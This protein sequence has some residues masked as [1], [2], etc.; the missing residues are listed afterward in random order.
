M[1]SV[2]RKSQCRRYLAQ[3]YYLRIKKAAIASQCAWRGRVARRELRKLQMVAKETGALQAA[4]TKLENQV[5]ELTWRLQL[6]K[7]M[8][9][10]IEEAKTRENV[11]LQS[12]LQEMQLQFE[13]IKELLIKE[14][15][16]AK[17][18]V[19][20]TPV[21]QEVP[22]IDHEMINNLGME[23]EKLKALVNSLEKKIDE[24][25]KKYEETSKLS[26]ERLKQALEA[27]SKIIQLKAAMQRSHQLIYTCL[28]AI[29][30]FPPSEVDMGG[31]T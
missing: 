5:E 14:R 16:A 10:D 22:V 21:I 2:I 18:A 4:K 19:E 13:E 1:G 25:E 28:D 29:L 15:E 26:E 9:V 11:K 6:E 12:H 7:R 31:G 8:R 20:Q 17:L 24:T 23:N 27:E 30:V 3:L